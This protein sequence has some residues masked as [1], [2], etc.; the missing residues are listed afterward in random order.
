[1]SSPKPR[2]LSQ[3]EADAHVI[4]N[5]WSVGVGLISFVPGTSLV[6]DACDLKMVHDV[7]KAF[8]V[9][10][11]NIDEITTAVAAT[12]ASKAASDGVLSFFPIIG[13]A[14]KAGLAGAMTKTVG[15][16]VIK[17]FKT[18]SPLK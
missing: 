7:A 10:D 15:E 13:W 14:A 6:L 12:A 9:E 1:M 16:F 2:S 3:A 17:Y 11:Y 4:V 18:R 8:G 5:K